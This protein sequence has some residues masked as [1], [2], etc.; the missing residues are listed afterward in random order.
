[1]HD[2]S[3]AVSPPP[4]S[5][6]GYSPSLYFILCASLLLLTFLV[7]LATSFFSRGL[8]PLV[9]LPANSVVLLA[10]MVINRAWCGVFTSGVLSCSGATRRGTLDSSKDVSRIIAWYWQ[11][12]PSPAVALECDLDVST[13]L[14]YGWPRLF[15]MTIFF[16]AARSAPWGV[17]VRWLSISGVNPLSLAPPPSLSFRLAPGASLV[18]HAS[19]AYNRAALYMNGPDTALNPVKEGYVP[20]PLTGGPVRVPRNKLFVQQLPLPLIALSQV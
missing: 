20:P 12:S 8:L 17:L 10:A 14:D 2:S 18:D 4:L 11:S 16:C 15:V 1:M 3:V 6:L 9:T 19:Q 5:P 7:S 13:F